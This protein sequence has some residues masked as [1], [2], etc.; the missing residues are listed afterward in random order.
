[1]APPVNRPL[2]FQFQHNIGRAL[3]QHD[4]LPL[5]SE[6]H[7]R[8]SA[9]YV[10]ADQLQLLE[11]P[12]WQI[13]YGRRGT[14]KTLL[15]SM[16]VERTRP[17]TMDRREVSLLIP[18]QDCMVSPVGREVTDK[19]RALGYF[20]TFLE[21]LVSDLVMRLEELLGEPRFLEVVSGQRR[22]ITDRALEL[23][24]ALLDL[25]TS[26][27]PVSAYSDLARSERRSRQS[28]RGSGSDIKAQAKVG[29]DPLMNLS[30]DLQRRRH[31]S[32]ESASDETVQSGAVPRFALVRKVLIEL[33]QLLHIE[34][35]TILI[36]EWSMLDPTGATGI[37]PEFA[38]LLKRTFHGTRHI[39]I[40]MATNRYQTRLSNR[41]AAGSYRGLQAEADIFTAANLDRAVLERTDL[42]GFYE[43]L[44]FKRLV[45]FDDALNYFDPEGT[46]RPDGTFVQSMFH[47]RRAFEELVKGSEGIPRDFLVLFNQIA[48]VQKHSVKPRWTVQTV[49]DVIRQRS[50]AGQDDI[51][52]RSVTSQVIDPCIRNVAAATQSRI[53]FVRREH[54][55]QL[56]DAL[57]ELLEKRLIHDYPREDLP[58][59]AR[60]GSRA[61]LVDYGL[62]LDWERTRGIPAGPDVD[63]SALPANKMELADWHVDPSP[64]EREDRVRCPHCGSVFTLEQP[65]YAR[66]GLCPE[67]FEP[68][69]PDPPTTV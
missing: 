28:A 6:L 42:V 14:G 36:D 13:V 2:A 43:S 34:R 35:L 17:L 11:T 3:Q 46:G 9:L 41:G 47:N 5:R 57:D 12:D 62:W 30:A 67:C 66:K 58:A 45:L 22:R 27:L 68:V 44:M 39:S 32:E 31:E 20:Q 50:V 64:I 7:R 15:F 26:G 61:Y 54:A 69:G 40:K 25:A 52:Y 16:Y 19:T 49:Q 23:Q 1:M 53:F 51:E 38:N 33:L 4:K 55:A 21:R 59:F 65:A 48:R 63:E 37:Q 10:D 18:T 60:E 29:R 8:Y 24:V 56:D